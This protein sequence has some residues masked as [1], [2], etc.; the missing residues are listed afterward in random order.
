MDF[1]I[2]LRS[3]SF[4]NTSKSCIIMPNKDSIAIHERHY[5]I[6]TPENISIKIQLTQLNEVLFF[7]FLKERKKKRL[8]LLLSMALRVQRQI[9]VKLHLAAFSSTDLQFHL[10]SYIVSQAICMKGFIMPA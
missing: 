10:H 9:A 7:F 5:N 2:I 6:S 3:Q 4:L 1:A 8:S